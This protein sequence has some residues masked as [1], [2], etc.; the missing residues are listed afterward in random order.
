MFYDIAIVSYD[1]AIAFDDL[2]M[3]FGCLEL[4]NPLSENAVNTSL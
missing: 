3:L 2:A 4:Y 1:I